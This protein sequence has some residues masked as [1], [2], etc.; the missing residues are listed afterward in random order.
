LYKI[1]NEIEEKAA[2]VKLTETIE[3][4]MDIVDNQKERI[5]KLEKE[6]RE[7]KQLQEITVKTILSTKETAIILGIKP[8]T[9][10]KLNE[11]GKLNGFKYTKGGYLQFKKKELLAYQEENLIH[12]K[13]LG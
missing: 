6:T 12:S 2:K 7:V 4:L 13:V 9:V 8:R 1:E 10:R 3:K 11:E 5:A